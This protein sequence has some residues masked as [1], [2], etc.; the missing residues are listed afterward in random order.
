[1]QFRWPHALLLEH[2][3]GRLQE[4]HDAPAIFRLAANALAKHPAVGSRRIMKHRVQNLLRAGDDDVAA[5]LMFRFIEG[6]WRRGR[7]TS[8]TLKD[9]QLLDSRVS[10]RT[11]AEYAFWRGE[12][13]RHTGKLDEARESAE[14]ALRVFQE[15]NDDARTAHAMRLLGHIDSDIGAPARGRER[16]LKAISYFEKIGDE[17]GH[18]QAQVVLGEID[19]LLGEHERARGVLLEARERCTS[20]G[21]SL[22]G[23]QCLIL[24]AMISISVG[25]HQRSRELLAEARAAFDATGYRLGLAQCDTALGHADHR[26]FEMES[27]RSHALGA[28]ASFRELHNPRGEAACERLL[29][30]IAIDTG[31]YEASAL[32]ARVAAKIYE[33][34]RDPWGDLEALLLLAQVALAEGDAAAAEIVAKCD[35]LS[36]DEAEPRQ[37]RHLTRAW[38]AH[39][40]QRGADAAFEIDAARAVYGDRVR[41]GDHTPH[42]LERFR[43]MRWAGAAGEAVEAWARALAVEDPEGS[44]R[45]RTSEPNL[46][47]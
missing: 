17:A 19:Y 39:R 3:L 9:L 4:R 12:A 44:A 43:K 45:W 11:A 5:T 33:K 24:L 13:L 35:A 30:M 23:A 47:R 21:D 16:V 36:V 34:I 15:S 18:A 2:L 27:A 1:D 25:G 46:S 28:R 10:G 41:A 37:H 8:A 26:A 40:E 14:T 6:S 38:L 7:D 20:L 32:H 31:D 22:G 29:A 42:L